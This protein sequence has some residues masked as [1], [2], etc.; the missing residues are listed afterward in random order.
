MTD[1][2]STADGRARVRVE[3]RYP[4]AIEKVWR[5]VTEPEHLGAWFPS[6]VELDLRPGG[7]MRF[8]AFEEGEGGSGR[9][10]AVE[11]PHLFVFLW[12]TEEIRI[13]LT[14]EAGETVVALTH[15]FDDRPLGAS[16]AA[17]WGACLAALR[18]VVA[19]EPV[20]PAG[21]MI[22]EHEEL[23][24]LFGL[25]RPVLTEGP[26]GWSAR[27]DR[28]LTCPADVA[29]ELVLDGAPAPE[30][31][32]GPGEPGDHVRVALV[33]GSGH[34]A[35]LVLT[36]SGADPAE[37]EAAVAQ[38]QGAVERVAREAAVWAH[39]REKA[40]VSAL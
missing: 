7:A 32:P 40:D 5:A 39:N 20:P 14:P 10:V 25:D 33:P 35:R 26:D 12:D 16:L 4:H 22:D 38:W 11:P 6:P 27:F 2:M 1:R 19:G 30:F 15:T 28:Q 36:V 21:R 17:G 37:R 9:V 29:W 8:A 34:G 31:D 24:R 3:R 23:V 13:E 18:A